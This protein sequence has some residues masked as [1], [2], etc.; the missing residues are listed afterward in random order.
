MASI[1]PTIT[2]AIAKTSTSKQAWDIQQNL[3]DNKSYTRIFSLCNF[4]AT[5]T[6]NSRSMTEYL[7][8]IRNVADELATAGTPIP[9]D[10]LAVKNLSGLGP[11]YDSIS[12]VI[13]TR[14]IPISYE[15]LYNKFLNR[16]IL[17]KHNESN[18]ASITAAVAQ[19]S[20]PNNFTPRNNKRGQP[21]RPQHP[22]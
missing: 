22:N 19:K 3:Y 14:D 6:K 7:R 21:W 12:A 11:E 16:E 15:E 13:Q 17:L 8:E 18:Q 4:L 1:D 20:L 5:I 10:E 2:S 9:D